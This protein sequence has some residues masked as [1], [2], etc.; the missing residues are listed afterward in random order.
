MCCLGYSGTMYH[1][2]GSGTVVASST[3]AGKKMNK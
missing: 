3:K 2:S 1:C